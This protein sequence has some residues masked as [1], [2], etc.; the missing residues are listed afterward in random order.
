MN[1]PLDMLICNAGYLGGGNQRQLIDGV[2]K[3]FVINHLGHFKSIMKF[4]LKIV[5]AIGGKTIE[6]GA[7]TTCYVATSAL[8]A[9]TI[10]GSAK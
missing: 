10:S 8:L 3:H 5:A 2:E 1:S 4:G 7:A 6:E 9:T